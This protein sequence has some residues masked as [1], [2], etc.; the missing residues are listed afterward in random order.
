MLMPAATIDTPKPLKREQDRLQVSIHIH[1]DIIAPE[2][3]RRKANVWLLMNAGHLVS[4]FNP[5]LMIA[6]RLLWRLE[7]HHGVPDLQN[8]GH[9]IVNKIGQ[10]HL[11]A[12]TG[13]PVLPDNFLDDLKVAAD[14]LTVA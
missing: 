13:E 9:A 10:M 2:V 8:P 5:E 12:L 11:D 14:A 1:A 6:D 3:A 7:V 4:A